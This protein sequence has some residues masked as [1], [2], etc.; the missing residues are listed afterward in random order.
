[1]SSSDSG[2]DSSFLASS[3]LAGAPAAAAV[4]LKVLN[5]YFLKNYNIFVNYLEQQQLRQQQTW[6]DP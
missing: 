6:M 2:S 1:M 3:F 5:Y 4:F